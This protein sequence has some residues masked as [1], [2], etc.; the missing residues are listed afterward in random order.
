[1]LHSWI[2]AEIHFTSF[3]N[4]LLRVQVQV[5]VEKFGSAPTTKTTQVHYNCPVHVS[6]VSCRF[7]KSRYT[8]TCCRQA[9][10]KLA[11][12]PSTGELRGNVSSGFWNGMMRRWN[13]RTLA[14]VPVAEAAVPFSSRLTHEM[15]DAVRTRPLIT[16]L[17]AVS[18][19]C[20]PACV[21]RVWS[22]VCSDVQRATA[23]SWQHKFSS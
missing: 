11:T 18:D 14:V 19:V 2:N 1:M 21:G 10:N 3:R 23:I 12:S 5:R 9:G 20:I 16:R 13:G 4:K 8:T 6:V 22:C 17:T 15:A 7:A